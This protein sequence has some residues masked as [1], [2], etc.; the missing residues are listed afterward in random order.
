MER[1]KFGFLPKSEAE[2][3]GSG[4]RFT[5]VEYLIFI[6]D[7]RLKGLKVRSSTRKMANLIRGVM[8]G[9][10]PE[11]DSMIFG[12]IINEACRFFEIGS[13]QE[14]REQVKLEFGAF[15]RS[16]ADILKTEHFVRKT[17]KDLRTKVEEFFGLK[18]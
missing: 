14:F 8:S 2:A 4:L 17:R 15:K 7:I 18:Y 10:L 9:K 13:G 6:S 12:E 5:V 11:R 3:L 1:D 16:A